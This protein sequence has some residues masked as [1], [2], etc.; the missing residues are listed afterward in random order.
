[1]TVLSALPT[2]NSY[3][4]FPGFVIFPC[5][6]RSQTRH[7]QQLKNDEL[8]F[9]LLWTHWQKK[10]KRRCCLQ[11]TERALLCSW[12]GLLRPLGGTRG[13]KQERRWGSPQGRFSWGK[14]PPGQAHKRP[15]A[16][17]FFRMLFPHQRRQALP[18]S[19]RLQ[20]TP[21]PCTL[22]AALAN[23]VLLLARKVESFL[24]ALL[25]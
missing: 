21:L 9:H 4:T 24:S 15:S 19:R 23:L 3:I 12:P 17:R 7:H 16:A 14:K 1:M 25:F 8:C 13:E 18:S 20:F 2:I 5:K 11:P 22:H 6:A 10:W